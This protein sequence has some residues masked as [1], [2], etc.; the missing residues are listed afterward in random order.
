MSRISKEDP[1]YIEFPARSNS[2]R[3]EV[4]CCF[5]SCQDDLTYA[6]ECFLPFDL[7][8][9]VSA[10]LVITMAS[11]V[12][13]SLIDN[14]EQF[15]GALS[16]VLDEMV[17]QGNL[18]AAGQKKELNELASLCESLKASPVMPGYPALSQLEESILSNTELTPGPIGNVDNDN[19]PNLEQDW[20]PQI[21]ESSQSAIN[22]SP[23]QLLE[24]ADMLNGDILLDWL[25]FPSRAFEL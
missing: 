25:D 24:V 14:H 6:T 12:S 22:M 1:F 3:Y 10:G 7:E 17:D 23:T 16:S 4:I 5:H 11:L 2:I 8:S 9:A 19:G 13:P 21:G 20:I 18:I 15:L